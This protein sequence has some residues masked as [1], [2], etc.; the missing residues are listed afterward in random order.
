LSALTEEAGDYLR[1]RIAAHAL[2]EAMERYRRERQGPV[3]AQASEY[4]RTLTL[5]SF[6][7]LEADLDPDG[8][9]TLYALR[10]GATEQ[11]LGVDALSDGTLDQLY[12]ALRLAVHVQEDRPALPFILDDILVNFDDERSSAA[13]RVLAELAGRT[14]VIFFTHHQHLVD[15]ALDALADAPPAV[16]ALPGPRDR[17]G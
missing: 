16:H 9:P 13:L 2:R 12:L 3:L 14:Q 6:T 11:Q 10:T 7:G 17:A 15:L 1:R 4:F 5:G 8:A